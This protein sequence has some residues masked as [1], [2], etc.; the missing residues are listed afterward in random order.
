MTLAEVQVAAVMRLPLTL[1]S[2]AALQGQAAKAKAG[3]Q[4]RDSGGSEA[5]S[6]QAEY[7]LGA[8]GTRSGSHRIPSA[9]IPSR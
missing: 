9:G 1:S 8:T 2:A 4:Y 7:Q 6:S 3:R 5:V